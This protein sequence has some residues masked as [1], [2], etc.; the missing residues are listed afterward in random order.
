MKRVAM[1]PWMYQSTI[2]LYIFQ[3]GSYGTIIIPYNILSIIDINS[4]SLLSSLM[5]VVDN[6]CLNL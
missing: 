6:N 4:A 1:K 5:H 3:I 2:N